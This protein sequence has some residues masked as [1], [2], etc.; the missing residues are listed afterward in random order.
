[1]GIYRFFGYGIEIL[2]DGDGLVQLSAITAELYVDTVRFDAQGANEVR[3]GVVF[4]LQGSTTQSP[5]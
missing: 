5:S 3:Y 1:M 4:N 2:F